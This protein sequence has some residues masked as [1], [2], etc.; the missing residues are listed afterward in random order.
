M[1]DTVRRWLAQM[2]SERDREALRQI[3]DSIADRMSSQPTSSA[4]LLIK[5]GSSPLA[6]IGTTAYQGVT[7]GKSVTIAA[8]SPPAIP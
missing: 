1:I 4:G 6:K 8:A 5:S 3:L 2:A 7:Q